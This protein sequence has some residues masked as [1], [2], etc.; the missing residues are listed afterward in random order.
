MSLDVI[1]FVTNEV[2]KLGLRDG[3]VIRKTLGAMDGLSLVTYD[4]SD[5]GSS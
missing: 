3:R 4:G 2:T 5:V 1:E